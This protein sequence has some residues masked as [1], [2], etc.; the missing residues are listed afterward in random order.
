MFKEGKKA[1]L[2]VRLG[3]TGGYV[4]SFLERFYSKK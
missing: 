1:V 3:I 4:E 2:T